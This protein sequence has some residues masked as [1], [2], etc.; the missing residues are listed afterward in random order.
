MKKQKASIV[1]LGAIVIVLLLVILYF[2]VWIPQMTEITTVSASELRQTDNADLVGVGDAISSSLADITDL[3]AHYDSVYVVKK[4]CFFKDT[5]PIYMVPYVI[6]DVIDVGTAGT[7]SWNFSLDVLLLTRD[8]SSVVPLNGSVK[9]RNSEFLVEAN[10]NTAI[11]PEYSG[12]R[13]GNREL[14]VLEN[15]EPNELGGYT[16]RFRV[17]TKNSL[18]KVNEEC[19]TLIQWKGSIVSVRSTWLTQPITFEVGTNID[20]LNNAKSSKD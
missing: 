14:V 15:V 13:L 4:K 12:G 9:L 20:Y 19:Q 7:V 8:G 18:I 3:P 2:A 17:A 10:T 1:I 5:E 16:L 6:A 11:L